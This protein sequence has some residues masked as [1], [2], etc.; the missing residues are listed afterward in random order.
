MSNPKISVI[1]PVYNAESTLRRCV[2]SVLAQTYTDFE[3]LL[4]DDGSTDKSGEMCDEYAAKDSRVRVFH[5]E[6]GGV[7]SARNVGLDNAKGEWI[8][9]LDSDDYIE[10]EFLGSIVNTGNAELIIG[11]CIWISDGGRR[12]LIDDIP[13]NVTDRNQIFKEY[14][15]SCTFNVPWGKLFKRSI[16]VDNAIGFNVEMRFAEDLCF[17]YQYISHV[18]TVRKSTFSGVVNSLVHYVPSDFS[19]KYSMS[20]MEASKHF[21]IIWETYKHLNLKCET[22]ENRILDDVFEL[23]KSDVTKNPSPWYENPAV[24]EAHHN[25]AYMRGLYCRICTFFIYSMKIYK[26]K[27]FACRVFHLFR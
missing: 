4:I 10:E 15:Y 11:S 14:L 17:V 3:C 13:S 19:Q 2:D 24:R 23:C 9:F 6:N 27:Y 1:I 18:I 7:S 5:K 21:E 16:I 26:I 12:Q 8:T 25:R 22:F 20:T